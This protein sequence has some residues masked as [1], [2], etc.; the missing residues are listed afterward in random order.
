MSL[1]TLKKI[2]E[3][4]ERRPAEI[5]KARAEGK[6]VVGWLN[7]NVPEELIYALDLI[8]IHLGNGGNERLVELGSRYISVMNCVFTRQVVGLFAEGTDP[9]IKNSDLVIIDVT[10]KQL[11][12]VAEIIK[13][14]FS[15][16]TEIIGVPY[17]FDVPAGKT[18]FRNE[19][20][21]FTKK[22]E[23][24][25]G[26]KIEQEKLEKSVEIHNEIREAIKELYLVQAEPITPITWREVYEVVEAGYYLDKQLYLSLLKELLIELKDAVPNQ[27]FS[28]T[29]PRIFISGSIIPPGDRKILDI[30]EEKGGRIVVDDLWSGF[31]PH[32][33]IKIEDKSIEG[34]AD[35]YISRH[36]HASLPH[37]D[38][39]TDK[40]LKNIR[41]LSKDFKVDGVLFHSLRYCDSFTFKANETKNV[42]K[43]DGISFLE[44]HTEYAGSD[45]EAI[46][47]RIEAFVEMLKIKAPNI[48]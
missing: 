41:R 1:L 17:N 4:V 32:F 22:L 18:Y 38:I 29:A 3:A 15:I 14:Y 35:G 45:F 16:N 24:L 12:R 11:Y 26:K 31:A 7:Y 25:A 8:P 5:E 43:D 44:I 28:E 33:D 10:C 42:L 2:N 9:Y 6:K 34:I 23:E 36:T 27:Q 21:A 47:T 40:R 19:I 37:L 39:D 13:H 48:V 46:G 30:L 20:K